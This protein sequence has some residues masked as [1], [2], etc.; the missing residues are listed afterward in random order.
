MIK[1][2]YDDIFS[3]LLRGDYMNIMDVL[4]SNLLYILVFVALTVIFG[5]CVFF[6]VRA[7]K[8]AKEMGISSEK[9]KSVIRSSVI[10]S[11][12][13]S[14][15]IIIGLI[16]LVPI[17]GVPWPW[18]RL[19]V[20]GSLPYE[21]TAAD[22]AVKAAGYTSLD[23]FLKTG[24]ADVVGAILFVMSIAIMGGMVFNIFVLKR[25]HMGV[26]KAGEKDT[27]VIDLLLSVLVIG[28]MSVFVPVQF[29][30]SKVHASVLVISAIST[31]V[32]NWISKKFS[33]KWL[34]DFVM[35]FALLIGMISAVFLE[36]IFL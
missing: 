1:Y 20:V 12:V 30:T 18:F 3:N 19:S 31:V 23:V 11:I 26:V 24:T 29:T 6:F 34:N 9:I 16:T 28:M 8:R 36:R 21:I 25:M 13:P 17:L 32:L 33:V 22:Q 10:F 4:N 7:K 35:S 14:I 15:S 2:S 5:M 27:P